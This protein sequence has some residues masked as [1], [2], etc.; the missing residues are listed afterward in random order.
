MGPRIL[1]GNVIGQWEWHKNGKTGA[2][3]DDT[4]RCAYPSPTHWR[5]LPAPPVAP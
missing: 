4:G 1:L 5:P 2:W 3:K